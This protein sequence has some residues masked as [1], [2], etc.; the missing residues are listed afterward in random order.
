MLVTSINVFARMMRH[1]LKYICRYSEAPL[2]HN[3]HKT[4]VLGGC[5]E[6]EKSW[7]TLNLLTS[8]LC[9]PHRVVM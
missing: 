6:R 3:I 2:T 5:L 8:S 7:L 1:N 4:S 9:F